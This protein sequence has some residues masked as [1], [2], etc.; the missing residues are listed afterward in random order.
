MG[1]LQTIINKIKEEKLDVQHVIECI[2]QK[3]RIEQKELI[4]LDLF[5]HLREIK[6]E[7][8]EFD[9]SDYLKDAFTTQEINDIQLLI[10]NNLKNYYWFQ[11]IRDLEQKNR[12]LVKD[13]F[14]KI[15]DFY[16]VRFDPHFKQCY[17]D[18]DFHN[19]SELSG[20]LKAIEFLTQYYI[21]YGFVGSYIKED[22]IQETGVTTKLAELY[23]DLF[24]QHYKQL[25]EE[26]IISKLR[27]IE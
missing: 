18:Y 24:E 21:S 17:L 11:P 9:I 2:K 3:E 26:Y 20:V 15:F 22:F 10:D 8:K 19:E 1:E 25:R 6:K 7:N 5:D 12:F 16:L 14:E 23:V 4:C 27:S 13:L